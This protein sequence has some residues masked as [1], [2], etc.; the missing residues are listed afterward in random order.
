MDTCQSENTATVDA[1][2]PA[3]LNPASGSALIIDPVLGEDERVELHRLAPADM[4]AAIRREV[5]NKTPRII[6][7]GGDG[8]I[9]LAAAEVA[10]T[11]TSLAIVPG[12]TLNHFARRHGIPLDPGAALECAFGGEIK[13]VNAGYVN[14]HLFI[15][16]CSLGAYAVFVRSREA[17]ER[18]MNYHLAS[19][20]AGVRRLLRL[21]S[22]R[23]RLGEDEFATPLVFVGVGERELQFPFLGEDKPGGDTALHVIAIKHDHWLDALK[24]ALTAMFRG[25]GPLDRENAVDS[26]VAEQF[27]VAPLRPRKRLLVAVDGELQWLRPPLRYRLEKGILGVVCPPAPSGDTP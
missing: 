5:A 9:A 1:A 11:E 24:L 20:L 6:V 23:F 13:A 8:T 25:V 26:R 15:N 22:R 16:T 14:E 10:G 21:R 2:I 12:G 19:A 17:L 18:R 4:A 7:S 27:T 3:F